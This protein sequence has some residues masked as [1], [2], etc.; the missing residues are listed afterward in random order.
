[1]AWAIVCL[2]VIGVV[3]PLLWLLPSKRERRVA[4]LRAAARANGLVVELAS[5]PDLHAK[6]HERVSA[7]GVRR[8][9]KILCAAYR[10]PMPKPSHPAPR[11]L[12]LKGGGRERELAVA[13]SAPIAGWRLWKP[14]LNAPKSPAYW[15]RVGAI[16]DDLPGDCVAVET[17]PAHTA[18]YGRERPGDLAADAVVAA[19]RRGLAAL[20]ALH[21]DGETAAISAAETPSPQGP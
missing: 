18:W 5:V 16:V 7:G 4:A 14:A 19:I 3:G 9:T 8:E 20:A 10:L 21:G 15:Q 1:M 13:G 17:D 6:P 2:V 12:L 11:W